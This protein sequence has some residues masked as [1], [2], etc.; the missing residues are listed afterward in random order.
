MM[1]L[2]YVMAA[3]VATMIATGASA[4]AA[5][6]VPGSY[7]NP[8]WNPPT[9]P[10]MIESSLG[11]GIFSHVVTGLNNG[12]IEEFKIIEDAD[13]TPSWGDSEITP[14]NVRLYGDADG[15]STNTYD[16][17]TGVWVDSDG[18]PLQV[19]GNFMIAAAGTAN[20][21]PSDPAFAMTSRGGG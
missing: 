18:I 21:N 12:A 3:M 9:S 11:S 20:W 10:V 7:T 8:M 19:V 6:Y 4:F 13:N 2:R 15:S 5:F 14:D 1:R 16:S 17:G